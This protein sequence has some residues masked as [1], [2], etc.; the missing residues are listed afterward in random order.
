MGIKTK[1]S[2]LFKMYLMLQDLYDAEKQLTVT[3]M[4]ERLF[5][6]RLDKTTDG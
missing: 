1:H 6:L 3:C 2:I 5:V 4:G